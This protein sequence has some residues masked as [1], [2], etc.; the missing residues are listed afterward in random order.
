MLALYILMYKQE[1]R[2]RSEFHLEKQ[3]NKQGYT[4]HFLRL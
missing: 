3:L 1:H 2:Q 4:Y